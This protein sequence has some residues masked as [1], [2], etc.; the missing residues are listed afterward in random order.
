MGGDGP[1]RQ[2]HALTI[3]NIIHDDISA[4]LGENMVMVNTIIKAVQFIM[5]RKD[6]HINQ[7]KTEVITFE[8]RVSQL[9]NQIDDVNQYERRD[10]L[11]ISGPSFPQETNSE[12]AA[13]VVVDTIREKIKI[14]I[15]HNDIN[16]AHRFGSKTKQNKNKP[17]IV[18]L[19]NCPKKEEIMS[20]CITMRPNLYINESLTLKRLSIFKTIWNIRKLHREQF[21]QCYTRDGKI[22]V[23]LKCS[24]L[25][26]MITN[27]ES[28]RTFLDKFPALRDNA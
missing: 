4:L 9:E 13:D 18:K 19:H 25:K 27:Y 5:H 15:S 24:N 22:Y 16:V 8:N 20:A 10:T 17:M 23:K 26:H 1:S 11:I 21:Q 2:S 14:N 6:E 7:L 3:S 28:L 12:S